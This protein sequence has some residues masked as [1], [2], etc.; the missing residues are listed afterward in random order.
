MPKIKQVP[1]QIDLFDVID[2]AENGPPPCPHF[3]SVKTG[4]GWGLE[5]DP[6][7]EYYLEWVHADPAC[8]RSKFPG[9]KEPKCLHLLKSSE[10]RPKS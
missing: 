1:G 8:R 9:K 10:H 3:P 5:M 4:R 2:E 7:S 6:K